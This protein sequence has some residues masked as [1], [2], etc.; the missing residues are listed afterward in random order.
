MLFFSISAGIPLPPLIL[1]FI[2]EKDFEQN[3]RRGLQ[4]ANGNVLEIV[5][6]P[7]ALLFLLLALVSL[8]SPVFKAIKAKR[9]A[10]KAADAA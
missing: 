8:L 10:A 7:I 9:S 1:G 5:H 3:L 6:H 4:Y 2:L